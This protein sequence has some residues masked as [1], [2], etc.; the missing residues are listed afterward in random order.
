ME[1]NQPI[2]AGTAILGAVKHCY[3]HCSMLSKHCSALQYTDKYR[4]TAKKSTIR[5]TSMFP[6]HLSRISR[7]PCCS[8]SL[9]SHPEKYTSFNPSL[10]APA[11][12]HFVN[13]VVGRN[14]A[15]S[16]RLVSYSVVEIWRRPETQSVS[17]STRKPLLCLG[18][19]RSWEHFLSYRKRSIST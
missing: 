16:L 14:M 19:F 12:T 18:S 6:H 13:L 8:H 3:N 9:T 5:I 10:D 15:F 11:I 17:D 2:G 1:T 7:H 4:R